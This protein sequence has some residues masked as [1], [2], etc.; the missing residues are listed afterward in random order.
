MDTYT[1]RPRRH[2]PQTA[3]SG[4]RLNR[5]IRT[6][7]LTP[8]HQ[9]FFCG[10]SYG[11]RDLASPTTGERELSEEMGDGGSRRRRWRLSRHDS[12]QR[13]RDSEN[14][15]ILNG[16]S[17]TSAFFLCER[18][19][20]ANSRTCFFFKRGPVTEHPTLPH[21]NRGLYWSVTRH[22]T[23]SPGTRHSTKCSALVKRGT[24]QS[25]L[26]FPG[27]DIWTTVT[28]GTVDG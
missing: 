24:L 2:D 4:L 14:N 22:R 26:S 12:Q 20:Q 13:T 7:A 19:A 11:V 9:N 23:A 8:F 25:S 6:G 21:R 3:L 27:E 1:D 28:D 18:V 16:V 10:L 17:S 15:G 5:P